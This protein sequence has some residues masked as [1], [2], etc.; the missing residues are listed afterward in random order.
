MK[1][2]VKVGAYEIVSISEGEY[3]YARV[4]VLGASGSHLESGYLGG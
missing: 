1:L 3:Q 2:S 4:S